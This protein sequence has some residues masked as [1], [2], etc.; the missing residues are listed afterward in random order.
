MPPARRFGSVHRRAATH[1]RAAR[2]R[3]TVDDGHRQGRADRAAPPSEW[4][5]YL[6]Q[7]INASRAGAGAGALPF[8]AELSD[9]AE[10]RTS[11]ML[12]TDSFGHTGEGGPS[13]AQRAEGAGYG[14]RALGE[15]AA[16]LDAADVEA[17]HDN[18]LASPGHRA[19]LL[20]PAYTEVGLG[21]ERGDY[22]GWHAVFVTEAFGS[23]NARE[24][25]EPDDWF[26]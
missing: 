9:T 20:N 14:Y 1:A 21:I 7:L 6:L 11:W 8:D 10:R 4:E 17:L 22:R 5:T 25:A 19:N 23:P 18:L 2:G 12:A 16:V 15:N 3:T 24:A 26:V 13:A